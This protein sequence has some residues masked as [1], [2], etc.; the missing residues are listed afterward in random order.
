MPLDPGYI[1]GYPPG[2]RENGGQYSHGSFWVLLAFARSGNIERAVELLKLMHPIMHAQ[3]QKMC[4]DIK[5]N[6][7][8]MSAMCIMP[9]AK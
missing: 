6:P 4:K 9:K 3:T 7:M 1:K 2:I 5:S 8:R